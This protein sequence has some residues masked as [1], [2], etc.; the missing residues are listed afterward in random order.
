MRDA[1]GQSGE[2]TCGDGSTSAMLV[3]RY[4][5]T[6]YSIARSMSATSSEAAEVT[7]N[8]FASAAQGIAFG[9]LVGNVRTWLCATAVEIALARRQFVTR[10][11]SDWLQRLQTRFDGAPEKV[12]SDLEWPK[13]SEL[14]VESDQLTRALREGLEALDDRVRAAFVLYDLAGLSIDDIASILQT[15][16][17]EARARVHQARLSLHQVLD[18]Y[19]GSHPR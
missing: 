10:S 7:L 2:C 3:A 16:R 18:G 5:D 12:V 9:P 19:F 14:V 4:G 15:S 8:T 1:N 11:A 13:S 6:V 17:R